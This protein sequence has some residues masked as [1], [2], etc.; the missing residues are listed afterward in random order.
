MPE[1][2]L[3]TE[4]ESKKESETKSENKTETKPAETPGTGD[5]M[6]LILLMT[7]MSVSFMLMIALFVF[8]KRK[9]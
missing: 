6:P 7:V 4:S 2:K 1:T 5:S 8:W 9:A 3:E